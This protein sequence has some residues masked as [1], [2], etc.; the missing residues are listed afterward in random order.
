MINMNT[1]AL[2]VSVRIKR[3]Q[4][5]FNLEADGIIGSATL[6]AIEDRL[7]D[8]APAADDYSLLISD[9]GMQQLIQHEIA[10]KN[11]Y[12]RFLKHP[13]WPGGASGITIGIGYD[14][15]YSRASQIQ[16]DW[17]GKISDLNLE[18]LK[19]VS[20]LKAEKVKQQLHRVKRV[21]INYDAAIAVFSESTLPRYAAMT[22]KAY[23]GV[24]KLHADA[25]AALLSLVYNRGSAMSG[26]KR[27]EMAAIKSLVL[28]QDYAGIAQA[29]RDMKRLWEGKG[30]AGLLKR[31]DE[32]A[33]LIDH[34]NRHYKKSELIRV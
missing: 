2:S 8:A 32:E 18:K 29:I 28:Q 16:R 30:L 9:V 34:A 4:Q 25:Q 15:G 23:P 21:S 27:K 22:R 1:K 3:I 10:S 7:F 33:E 12:N 31:R 17:F 26:S 19:K 24:E 20:G 6:T 14:L 13:V 5:H 11:Y